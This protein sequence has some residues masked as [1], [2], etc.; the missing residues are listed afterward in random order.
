MASTEPVPLESVRSAAA[1]AIARKQEEKAAVKIA[2]ITLKGV[3]YKLAISNI[4]VGEK[5]AVR[6]AT[7]DPFEAYWKDEDKIGE[8]SLVI[9]VWL[10]RRAAGEP[11]L[12][13]DEVEAS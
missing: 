3:V 5:R 7:G 6:H 13:L 1:A 8:D 11:G 4:P 10:A 2:T 12:T 9:L